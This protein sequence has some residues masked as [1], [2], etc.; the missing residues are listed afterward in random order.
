MFWSIIGI[1][2]AALTTFSFVPQMLKMIKTGSARDVSP[3][4]LF[5]FSAGVMLWMAYG[6][7]LKNVII[8]VA[9]FITLI[10]LIVTL[11]LYFKLK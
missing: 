8:F 5:Q 7:Y 1:S 6:I 9:N 4:T 11:R 3:V 2:A 10:T